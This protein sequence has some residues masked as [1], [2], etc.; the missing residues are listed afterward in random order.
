MAKKE[1]D[2]EHAPTSD[3]YLPPNTLLYDLPDFFTTEEWLVLFSLTSAIIS[4][5]SA[6]RPSFPNPTPAELAVL[7]F[8]AT[9][10]ND[11]F[12]SYLV[13][14]LRDILPPPARKGMKFV[15]G[16][17]ASEG[18]FPSY[19]LWSKSGALPFYKKTL[20]ERIELIQSWIGDTDWVFFPPL[21]TF[22]RAI[23]RLTCNCWLRSQS[24]A[25]YEGD[26][27]V[28]VLFEAI[29]VRKR[30]TN[31]GVPIKNVEREGTGGMG[32]GIYPFEF[33]DLSRERTWT[34]I[35]DM[36]K[37]LRMETPGHVEEE[38]GSG[39]YLGSRHAITTESVDGEEWR[40]I[41][42]DVVIVGSGPG[43]AV[44]AKKV[45]EANGKCLV[46]EKGYWYISHSKV[47]LWHG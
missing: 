39:I 18:F 5:I 23:V 6:P 11:G 47:D 40:V 42:T 14:V 37:K 31:T 44:I 32:D 43:G 38:G 10:D 16:L 25:N 34:Q 4:P 26:V 28:S 24:K 29:G 12:R 9:I 45:S 7:S 35:S 3:A 21:R 20:D 17:L 13:Y 1:L 2:P 33:L 22:A 27:G 46:V 15:L 8:S 41:E 19:V 30:P 36:M